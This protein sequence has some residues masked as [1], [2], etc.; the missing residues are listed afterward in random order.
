[1]AFWSA[2]L[3]RPAKPSAEAR[4]SLTLFFL[5]SGAF[6]LTLVPHAIQFPLWLTLSILAAMV[7]RA[8]LEVYRLPLPSSTFAG[9]IAVI[10]FGLIIAQFGTL[11]GREP[12]TAFTA[13]LLAIKF[14]EMRRPRDMSLIIFSCFFVVMSALLFSQVVEL[15]VYC[16]IMMWV[17]V[18]LLLRVQMGDVAQDRLLR[19]LRISGVISLQ[20]APLTL[21]LFFFF[22]RYHGTLGLPLDDARVGFTDTVTPGSIAKLAQNDTKVMDV[23]FTSRVIPLSESMYW[24]GLVLWDYQDGAWTQGDTASA[25]SD[26][27]GPEPSDAVTQ[28]VTIRPHNQ[29]W[30]FALDMPTGQAK[31][32]AEPTSWAQLHS[33]NVLQLNYGKLD[34]LARYDVIS[35]LAPPTQSLS[36]PEKRAAIRLPHSP[37]D[38]IDPQVQQLAD[39]LYQHGGA[40][41]QQDY[42]NAVIR[43]LRHGGFTYTM[44]PDVEGQGPAWLPYFLFKSKTGFCEHFASA[45]AVL[46]RVEHVPARVVVGY[47]GAEFNPYTNLYTVTQGNAHAWAEVWVPAKGAAPNQGRWTRIDPTSLLGVGDVTPSSGNAKAGDRASSTWSP[48]RRVFCKVTCPPGLT[49]PSNSCSFVATRSRATGTMSSS[50]TTRNRN[51]ASP[52]PSAWARPRASVCSASASSLW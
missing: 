32:A 17:L 20:A 1:M 11:R 46:M 40:D 44:D 15:F 24:R 27:H 29:R 49:T 13:G 43:Y 5:L 41:K 8:F 18:A 6:L 35:I 38:N 14:Y 34:H 50:P 31:N 23:Q 52:N 16:L 42:I 36:E 10:F 25:W 33:G 26:T 3:A 19:L 9:I 4:P 37:N 47:L 48:A 7:G 12:G 39:Q 51:S 21:L 22:P 45:F 2:L 30:L 28:E